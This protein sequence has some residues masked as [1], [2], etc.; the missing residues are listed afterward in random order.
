MPEINP[1][2]VDG[3]S[4][5]WRVEMAGGNVDKHWQTMAPY[6]EKNINDHYVP[7]LNAH[8]MY[9]LARAGKHDACETMLDNL[10]RHSQQQTGAYATYWDT[11]GLP[12]IEACYAHAKQ[13]YPRVVELLNP[14]ADGLQQVGGSDAQD[15]IFYQMLLSSLI[16]TQHWPS[17]RRILSQYVA[18]TKPSP[19][20][21]R[22]Q[23]DIRD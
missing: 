2:Q 18:Q 19:L 3:V 8:Y 11:I 17:A 22:W 4:L 16:E 9:G 14:I 1:V 7:F 13:D 20:T 6:L 15:T 5:L 10:T 23:E 12:L 21:Q